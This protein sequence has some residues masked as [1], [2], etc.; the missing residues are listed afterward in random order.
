M[1]SEVIQ[2]IMSQMHILPR[3]LL[4]PMMSQKCAGSCNLYL[5]TKAAKENS[6]MSA[7]QR[8]CSAKNWPSFT[9]NHHRFCHQYYARQRQP[10]TQKSPKRHCRS[11]LIFKQNGPFFNGLHHLAQHL[12]LHRSDPHKCRFSHDFSIK[13]NSV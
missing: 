7:D 3:K 8:L 10:G 11:F 13:A 5:A 9:G 12:K 1:Y 4:P 6:K 2:T